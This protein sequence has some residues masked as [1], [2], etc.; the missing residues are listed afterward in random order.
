M[1]VFSLPEDNLNCQL[2]FTKLIMFIDMVEIL[3]GIADGK[4]LSIFDSVTCPPHDSGR[5]SL[6]L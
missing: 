1:S 3:F 6:F 4:I 2:I 5:V